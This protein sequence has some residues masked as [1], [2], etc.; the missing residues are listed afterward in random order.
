MTSDKTKKP[1]GGRFTAPTDEFVEQFTESVSYDK[2]LARYDIAG[3]IAH[4]KMLAKTKIISK[5]ESD[6][7]IAGL[8]QIEEDI[9][10][11]HFKW[12]LTPSTLNPITFTF[13]LSNSG[14]NLANDPNS[15]VQTGVKSLGCENK[16]PQLSPSHS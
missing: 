11:N 15:V 12:S 3:S 13:L 4:A 1:W 16:T 5:K 7:I 14:F 9:S 8:K 10:S 6:E 2:R